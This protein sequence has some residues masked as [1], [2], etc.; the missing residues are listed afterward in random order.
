MIISI[1]IEKEVDKILHGFMMKTLMKLR[2]E[3][4]LL[5]LRNTPTKTHR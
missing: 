1:N 2:I 3:E 4:I 5:N